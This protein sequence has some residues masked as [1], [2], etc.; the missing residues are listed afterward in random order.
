MNQGLKAIAGSYRVACIHL[1]EKHPVAICPLSR[2]G[3]LMVG[4]RFAIPSFIIVAHHCNEAS[5]ASEIIF[6]DYCRPVVAYLSEAFGIRGIEN[7]HRT[8]LA[9]PNVRLHELAE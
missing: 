5:F 8:V 1:K 3:K 7:E 9:R 6:I 4:R 2:Q